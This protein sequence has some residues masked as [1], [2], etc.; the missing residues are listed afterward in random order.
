[1]P[2]LIWTPRA[3]SDIQ[4][5]RAFLWPKNHDAAKRAMLAIQAGAKFIK[6]QPRMGRPLGLAE[7]EIREWLIEFGSSGYVLRYRVHA[8]SLV[9]LAVWHQRELRDEDQGLI[10]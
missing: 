6:R 5:L 3:Q 1:M 4:R 2:H 7:A 10:S 8:E 9:V